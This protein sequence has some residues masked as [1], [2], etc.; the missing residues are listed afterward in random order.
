MRKQKRFAAKLAGVILAGFVATMGLTACGS[1]SA[2]SVNE[3]YLV[4][5]NVNRITCDSV[6]DDTLAELQATATFVEDANAKKTQDILSL[7]GNGDLTT[8]EPL[9]TALT[10]KI[11]EIKACATEDPTP[12]PSDETCSAEFTQIPAAR[13]G[14]K[15][16][17][18]FATKYAAA[19]AEAANL[20]EAQ[21]TLL[22]EQSGK[23]ALTLATWSHAFGLY[24]DPNAWQTLVVDNC[25]SSE[26]QKLHNQLEGALTATG[27]TLEEAEAP[28]NGYNSG[29]SNGV[30][31]VAS[32]QGVRGDRKAIKVTLKDGTVVYIMV[33]C[34][35]PVYPGK[36]S[37]PEVPTDNP[38]VCTWNPALPPDSPDC[39][40][41]KNVTE[42]AYVR[43]NAQTGGGP[44][45]EPGP[46]VYIPPAEMEQPPATPHVDPAT[47]TPVLPAPAPSS[48]STPVPAKDPAP[49]P[50]PSAL[51]PSAAPTGCIIPQGKTSC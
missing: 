4:P 21:R 13:E 10:A 29:I 32:E 39:V 46:G 36:P 16:D 27:T 50:E 51:A 37:L 2:D 20:S 11:S 31:G 9:S 34:G 35:N 26:G 8:L 19:T 22:L 43:G 7:K 49:A 25:L 17:S 48:S 40:E 47:P 14:S 28:A 30:Y 24:E 18:D 15:V 3:A 41:P 45:A 1:A 6:D 42:G 38:P 33:R 23:D 12:K 44:K 5:T